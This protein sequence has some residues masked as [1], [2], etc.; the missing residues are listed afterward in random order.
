MEMM[1]QKWNRNRNGN[2][3]TMEMNEMQF[4]FFDLHDKEKLWKNEKSMKIKTM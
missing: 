3:F 4:H 1:L 2:D